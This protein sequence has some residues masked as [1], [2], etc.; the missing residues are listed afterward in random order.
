MNK[1]LPN[2]VYAGLHEILKDQRLYHHSRVGADYCH[3][4]DE[5]KDAVIN[6][7]TLMAP[8][9]LKVSE[10]EFN[11]RAKQMVWDELKK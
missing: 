11:A 7:I 8:E 1:V 10:A 5:G 3:L 6:W 4:T 9:M 2:Q